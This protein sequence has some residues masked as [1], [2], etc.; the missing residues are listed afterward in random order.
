MREITKI[1]A[2]AALTCF[3]FVPSGTSGEEVRIEIQNMQSAGG[4]YFTPLWTGFHDGTFDLFDP[5]G[6]ASS[7]LEALAELGD[8]SGVSA[9]F[10]LAQPAGFDAT[11]LGDSVGPPPFDPQEMI[12]QVFSIT[13]TATNRYFS[14]AAMVIPSND[15]FFGNGD[16]MGIELFNSAGLFNGPLTF[17]IT[18]GQIW[19]AGTEVN[20]INGGAAFS[21]NGGVS[22]SE[23]NPISLIDLAD[24]N[25]FL[26]SQT[27]AGTTIS[28]SLSSNDVVARISISVVPEPGALGL[29]TFIGLIGIVRRQRG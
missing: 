12:A 1:M 21:A 13:D 24:L 17:D 23:N 22:A 29:L 9:D 6:F 18:A 28:N 25:A 11:I 5:G 2:C 27:A 16:A 7:S 8:T 4:F 10:G 26:G 3:G 19:D 20:D 14:F 15:A